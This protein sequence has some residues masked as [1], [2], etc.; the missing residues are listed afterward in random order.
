[1]GIWGVSQPM[2]GA[3]GRLSESLPLRQTRKFFESP[4]LSPSPQAVCS[5]RGLGEVT[6]HGCLLALLPS[7]FLFVLLL[8][9][10]GH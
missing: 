4:P 3:E 2:E 10:H 8:H 9:L 6:G 5:F 1:M 7:E